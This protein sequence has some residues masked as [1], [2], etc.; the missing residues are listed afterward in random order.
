MDQTLLLLSVVLTPLAGAA[1]IALLPSRFSALTGL[2][3]TGVTCI[4]ALLLSWNASM[5]AP[6]EWAVQAA[7][8]WSGMAGM[9]VSF[10]L[11]LDGISLYLV[12]LSGLLFPLVIAY[13][14]GKEKP[15]Q[16]LYYIMLLL[17]EAGL[18]GFF[19]SLDLI[20]FYIFFEL[21]LIPGSFFIG[22]WGGAQRE[23]A[24]IRFFIYTL[25]GSLLMLVA[26]IYLGLNTGAEGFTSDYFKIREAG[27]AGKWDLHTGAWL[28][29]AFTLSFA[30]KTPLFPF[31]SW[32]PLAYSEAS[33]TGSVLLGALM[34]KM[35]VYGF[36]RFVLPFFPQASVQHAPF[37]ATLAVIGVIYGA[38]QAIQQTDL[39]RLIAFASISHLGFIVLGIFS[40]NTEAL[41][42]AVFQM[43]A[44]GISTAAMFFLVDVLYRRKGSFEITAYSGVAQSMPVFALLFLIAVMATVGLPGLSGFIGE[45]YILTGSFSSPVFGGVFSVVAAFSLILAAVYLLNMF[46][47]VMFGEADASFTPKDVARNEWLAVLPLT[48][49]MVWMGLQASPFLK[50]I[51]PDAATVLPVTEVNPAVPSVE[52]PSQPQ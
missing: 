15:Q 24:A 28:F 5:A 31:H 2:I 32:Q 41:G 21:V 16:K 47:K 3:F 13:E 1:L 27:I 50:R 30:I 17:L 29:A 36:I 12:A 42:G 8:P 51:R 38:W 11:G 22:I 10:S 45:F 40:F 33:T 44:H 48:V 52:T 35:G 34:S 6:G 19:V 37:I 14:W 39:K 26:I 43:T 46:R 20:L 9:D 18:I 23:K 7:F 49:L 4:A 25:A